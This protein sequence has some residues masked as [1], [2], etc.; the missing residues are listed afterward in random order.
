[1]LVHIGRGAA[2]RRRAAWQW[3]ARRREC[4][5]G[6][7]GGRFDRQPGPGAVL[8]GTGRLALPAVADLL[9]GARLVAAGADPRRRPGDAHS[10]DCRLAAVAT[11]QRGPLRR[12][13]AA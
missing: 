4:R 11:A 13:L 12:T 9:A 5:H 2:A 6:L 10:L 3:S 1:G 8:A 7:G